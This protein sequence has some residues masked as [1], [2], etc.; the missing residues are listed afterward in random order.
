[1]EWFRDCFKRERVYLGSP[2]RVVDL[3]QK[4]SVHNHSW[5]K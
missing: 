3:G 1:M 2:G 4:L 5:D